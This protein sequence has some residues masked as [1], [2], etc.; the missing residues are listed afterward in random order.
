MAPLTARMLGFKNCTFPV[1]FEV[2]VVVGGEKRYFPLSLSTT[3]TL[4]LIITITIII[5]N[6]IL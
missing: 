5:I 2:I 6:R 1:R 4:T 3:T